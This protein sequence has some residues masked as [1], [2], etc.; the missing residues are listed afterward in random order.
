MFDYFISDKKMLVLIRY[1]AFKGKSPPPPP[2]I[3]CCPFITLY[4]GSIG[5]DCVISEYEGTIYKGIKEI[6]QFYKG[7]K[8]NQFYKG[9]I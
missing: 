2:P 1:S 6:D 5:M 9:I 7:I 8:Y 4:L 3:Q